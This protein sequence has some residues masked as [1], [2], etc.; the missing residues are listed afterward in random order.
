MKVLFVAPW[1]PSKI[2]PR[3]FALLQMLSKQH[4]VRFLGLAS[5]T[6]EVRQAAELPVQEYTLVKRDRAASMARCALALPTGVALQQAYAN[7]TGLT[8]A[9]RENLRV[10][11]PDVVHLNVFRTAH[12]VEPCGDTP[13]IADLDEFRSEYYEQLAEGA[14]LPWRVVGRI[15]APRMRAREEALVRKGVPLILSAPQPAGQEKPNTC[16][17]RSPYDYPLATDFAPQRP[18]ILFVGRLTYEANVD[19]LMWFVDNCWEGIRRRHPDA[20]LRIVGTEPPPAVRALAGGGNVEIH[21]N[22]PDVDMHYAEAAVAIVPIRRGTGVQMKLIQALAAGV[23]T[24]ATTAVTSRAGVQHDVDVIQADTPQAWVDGVSRLLT[25]SAT[26]LRLSGNG[27][28]WARKNHSWEA[29]DE[30]L[31]TAYKSVT[32]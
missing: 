14:S 11:R 32:R 21:A 25:D 16:L 12:L 31:A 22:V 17:V 1:I 19:G 4:D 29:V 7:V 26:A 9:L 2:R 18:V 27:R 6:E 5:S 24:V 10:W 28:V 23:P 30:Q 8:A 3:S 13:V 20:L 15:E